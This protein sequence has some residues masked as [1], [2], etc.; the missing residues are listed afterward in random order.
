MALMENPAPRE[1]QSP[2]ER[3][4]SNHHLRQLPDSSTIL[5]GLTTRLELTVLT[6]MPESVS[7]VLDDAE[8]TLGERRAQTGRTSDAEKL[9]VEL[10]SFIFEILAARRG[11][12]ELK[13]CASTCRLWA[14][15]AL[16]VLYRYCGFGIFEYKPPQPCEH[17]PLTLN[18]SF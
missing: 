11:V 17:C 8:L 13:N 10:L 15:V 16:P 7:S 9:P 14:D 3:E 4:E 5:Q 1:T 18:Q 2:W 6:T 12:S